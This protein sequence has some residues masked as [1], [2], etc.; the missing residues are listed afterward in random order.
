M[1]IELLQLH[2][3][4]V[5]LKQPRFAGDED[6]RKHAAGLRI[7][8]HDVGFLQ[9]SRIAGGMTGKDGVQRDENRNNERQGKSEL[10][11]GIINSVY[12][13][14]EPALPSLQYS[15]TPTL[16]PSPFPY[17]TIA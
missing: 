12:R 14:R 7:G 6:R 16:Q 1:R 3:E 13:Q 17:F 4:T 2:I 9:L 10:S 15:I 5:F 8:E 11:P